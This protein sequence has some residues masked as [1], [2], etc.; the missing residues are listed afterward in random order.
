MSAP[1]DPRLE[2][3][4]NGAN[5]ATAWGPRDSSVQSDENGE[6][7]GC[8]KYRAAAAFLYFALLGPFVG[9]VTFL[10]G[11]FY[12]PWPGSNPLL[13]QGISSWFID[14]EGLLVLSV[15]GTPFGYVLGFIPACIA[16]FL[17]LLLHAYGHVSHLKACLFLVLVEAVFIVLAYAYPLKL[18]VLYRFASP[19]PAILIFFTH[20]V[21]TLAM[22]YLA[23]RTYSGRWLPRKKQQAAM[24]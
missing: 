16:G 5:S 12:L 13:E 10:I 2:T 19:G 6:L 11:V 18:G 3:C 20:A 9:T 17:F 21:P 24:A 8:Y 7:K 1:T 23:W 4:S 22:T 14:I 15:I